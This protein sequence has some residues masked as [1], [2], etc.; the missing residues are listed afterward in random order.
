MST[1]LATLIDLGMSPVSNDL[2]E[3]CSVAL[4]EILFPLHVMVCA[5]CLLVQIG[6]F[7]KP[8]DIFGSDYAYFS[9]FSTTWL[10]HARVFSERVLDRVHLAEGD[11][12]V[13]IASNDGYLLQNFIGK[14]L[15]VLGIE[16]A[17]NVAEVAVRRGVPTEV[18]FFGQELAQTIVRKRGNA[19]LVVA[20]NVLAHVPD[21]NDFVSGL[22]ELV[23]KH[24]LLSIEVPHLLA[25]FQNV[26]FDTIYHEHY[27]YFSLGT[28]RAIFKAHG[29]TVIDVERIPTHGG[30]LRIFVKNGIQLSES[31]HIG[32]ILRE[33]A[34]GGLG[35][36]SAMRGFAARVSGIKNRFLTFLLEAHERG[37]TVAGYGAAAKSTT[38]LNYCGV[39]SDLLTFVADISP[40]KQGR[41]IPGCR[42]AIVPP[43]AI[44]K[45]R[46]DY[47]VI[48]AW[49][50]R[51]EIVLQL[52]SIRSWNGKFV[53]ALPDLQIF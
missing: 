22:S 53:V 47:V 5:S 28:L 46:P 9:S 23:G 42:I 7:H 49:N 4:P 48:F 52:Q 32:E 11:L 17:A 15:D 20:N 39:R 16:P 2:V 3:P 18:A 8:S 12:V 25:L 19:G 29:M 10:E 34:E 14:G 35:S 21:I 1:D 33:E 36:A 41:F 43:D 31:A 6:E 51:Q 27:C 24:G 50:L 37:A 38:F 26:Q 30:S 44:Q 40:R 45:A 13:E